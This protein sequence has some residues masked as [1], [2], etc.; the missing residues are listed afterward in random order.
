M[1]NVDVCIHVVNAVWQRT[2]RYLTPILG[3]KKKKTAAFCD[4]K[5]NRN[6]VDFQTDIRSLYIWLLSLVNQTP[7]P[8][9]WMYCITSAARGN[10]GDVIHPALRMGESGSRDYWLLTPLSREP[11]AFAHFFCCLVC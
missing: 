7:I 3:Q 4:G 2:R 5:K 1:K 8:Q 11:A 10:A 6:I 9:L